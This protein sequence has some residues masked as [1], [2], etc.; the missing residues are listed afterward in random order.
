M[1]VHSILP[2][3]IDFP[4]SPVLFQLGPF[5]VR[6]YG[7]CYAIAFLVGVTVAGR[8][9]RATGIADRQSGDM[10]FWAIVVGLICARLYYVVQ[11]GLWWYLTHP[12]HILA[13]WEGGMAYYGAVFAVP[14]F[15]VIYS[16]R[17]RIDWWVV[18]DGAALFA[19]V[20]QPI[21][22]IGN[23]FNGE[24]D[25]LGP[26]SDLPWA[27][28][29]TKSAGRWA[30]APRGCL[31]AGRCLRAATGA[32]DPGRAARG[33]QPFSTSVRGSL[34]PLYLFCMRSVSSASSSFGRIR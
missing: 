12:E 33:S 20:G 3:V 2:L 28:A 25:M 30:T 6:W 17:K 18:L 34:P 1:A 24:V 22:R 31:P 32:A 21:G 5:A 10:A 13:V 16:I 27:F 29:Y 8:H 23:I 19:A 14:V 4:F 7:V 26:R 15:L 11:S 9:L